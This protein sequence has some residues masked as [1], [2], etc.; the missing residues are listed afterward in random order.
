MWQ[1]WFSVPRTVSE[2]YLRNAEST[3]GPPDEH[4]KKVDECE[5]YEGGEYGHEAHDD[6]DIQ[7]GGIRNLICLRKLKQN[8]FKKIV[9]LSGI[10]LSLV[11][12]DSTS[13]STMFI[14]FHFWTWTIEKNP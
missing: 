2:I 5:F 12:V 3:Y 13:N 8:L 14:E 1:I 9:T 11:K 7:G 4:V 10:W 6:K